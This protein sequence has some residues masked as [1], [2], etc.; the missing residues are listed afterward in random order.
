[1][2]VLKSGPRKNR[3]VCSNGHM[4]CELCKVRECI[5]KSKSFNEKP[6]KYIENLMENL[7]WHCCCHFKHGCQDIFET[8]C[9]EDH[10]KCCIYREINCVF[11]NCK[12]HVLFKDFFDHVEICHQYLKTAKKMDEKSFIV[13]FDSSDEATIRF[14]VPNFTQLKEKVY[15][16]PVLI[17]NLPWMVRVGPRVKNEIKSLG[18]FLESDFKSTNKKDWSC[19]VKAD[20]GLINRK[21]PKKTVKGDFTYLFSVDHLNLGT[22]NYI[23]WT[24]VADPEK[25]FLKDNTVTFEVKLV[26]DPPVKLIADLHKGKRCFFILNKEL[27]SR[28]FDQTY[29]IHN[30]FSLGRNPKRQKLC[31]FVNCCVPTK[32]ETSDA[33]FFL[34][35]QKQGDTL[36]FWVYFVGSPLE[37]KNYTF[38]LSIADDAGKEKYDFQ[39]KVCTLDKD[40]PVEGM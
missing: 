5:C 4:V 27:K 31:G 12:E 11:D 35:R 38:N 18:F 16:K 40:D 34:V 9:L 17:Q 14:E 20:V 39:G 8:K 36:R 32:L 25:G 37:S 21:D 13:S 29:Y 30:Y 19:Q 10:Q 28:R 22:P 1:M 2:S 3:Y 15:S 23:L 26:A 24:D 6:V 7:S 33:T